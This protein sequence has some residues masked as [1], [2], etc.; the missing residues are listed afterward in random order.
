VKVQAVVALKADYPLIMLL[1]VADLAKSTFFYHQARLDRPDPNHELKKAITMVFSE[2][3]RRYGRRRIHA[4]LLRQGRQVAKKTVL[5]MMR[6]LGL[7]CQVRKR[8][9]NYLAYKG[10][11]SIIAPN[12]LNRNF[13]AKAPNQKW[14]TDITDFQLHSGKVY[15]S[16][17]IDLFDR[18]VVAFTL[19]T[20]PNLSLATASLEQAISTLQPDEHPIVH[21]DQGF[22]YQHQYWRRALEQRGLTQSM[23][24]RGNCLDNAVAECFFGHLKEELFDRSGNPLALMNEITEYIQ[25]WNTTRIQTKLKGMSPA[26]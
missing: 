18:S 23:S 7:K 6:Q 11:S 12:V 3:K 14:V 17:V 16:P 26:E 24:R 2:S 15:L 5:K 10:L 19:G 21:S 8:R 25:W 9:H 22:Q 20:S 4:I 13:T 1:E